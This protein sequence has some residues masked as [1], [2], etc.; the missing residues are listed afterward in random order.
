LRGSRHCLDKAWQQLFVP[1]LTEAAPDILAIVD[2]HLRRAFQLLAAT[3]SAGPGWDPVSF[4]RSAV[5]PHPQDRY[6]EAIDALIDA[7]RDCLETLLNA[8]DALGVSYA[9]SWADSEVPILRRLSLHAWIHRTDLN[10]TAKIGWLR[11]RGW[12]FD[13]Q[14]HHEVSRLIAVAL[15]TAADD[16]ADALVADALAGPSDD[17]DDDARASQQFNALAWI[18]RHA[19]RLQSALHAFQQVQSQH[20]HFAEREHPDLPARMEFGLVQPRPPMAIE[21]LHELIKTNA[22]DAITQ[23]RNYENVSFPSAGSTWNDALNVLVETVRSHPLDGLAVLDATGGD[24]SDIVNSVISGWSTATLDTETAE[25]ILQQLTNIDLHTATRSLSTLLAEGGQNDANPTKWFLYPAARQLA[26][27]M[28]L[29]IDIAQPPTDVDDWLGRAINHP[30]G[31][32]AQF[33]LHAVAADWRAAGD[34]WAGIPLDTQAQLEVLLAGDDVRSALAEVIL[35]SQLPF[36]F[37]ADESWCEAHVLPL[38]DWADP[39][40]ARRAW[41]GYLTW[42]RANDQLLT[43]GLLDYYVAATAH[44]DAFRKDLRRQLWSHLA[45]VALFSELDPLMWTRSFTKTVEAAQRVEWMNQVTWTLDDMP[46]D[47]V[48]YQWQRW[49]R[50]YWQDR[51]GSIPLQ[52]TFDEASAMAAWV[53]YLTESSSIGEGVALTTA[54]PAGLREHGG[55]LHDLGD[56]IHHSPADFAKLIAHLLRSTQSP[57]WE[58]HDLANIVPQIR[59]IANPD[60][61]STIVEE[62]I[63]LGCHNATQW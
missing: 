55:I 52:L 5:E 51:T 41:D 6:R 34:H 10:S 18:K 7:A 29:A 21:V 49:M 22:T 19:P 38:L 48:E 62:A 53:T 50:Q 44:A 15:P 56:R 63:R 45:A 43:V 4:R 11:G 25:A 39:V 30:A 12:L 3:G 60:D 58:C 2:R 46:T 47:A 8:G 61:T 9:T 14:L 40:R 31:R 36:F 59:D 33:W 20:P 27:D 54:R 16:I 28:W 1:N 32:I 42:G 23:L 26:A 35:A 17:A 57:F 24:H 37:S 13:H